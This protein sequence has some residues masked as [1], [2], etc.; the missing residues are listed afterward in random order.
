MDLELKG[1]CHA[2]G[3]Y[4]PHNVFGVNKT[5]LFQKRSPKQLLAT[6]LESAL[7]ALKICELV[8]VYGNTD[9]SDKVRKLA[10]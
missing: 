6:S 3:K 5:A 2:T 9:E 4:N 1:I 7:K 8:S 10:Y